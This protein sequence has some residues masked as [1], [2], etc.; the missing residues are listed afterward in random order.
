MN[1]VREKKGRKLMSERVAAGV[2]AFGPAF[3]VILKWAVKVLLD[4][5]LGSDNVGTVK[6]DETDPVNIEVKKEN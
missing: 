4:D 3:K 2:A 5:E 1:K 6:P